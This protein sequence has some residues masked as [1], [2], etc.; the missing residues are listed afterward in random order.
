M[1]T[2]NQKGIYLTV[3]PQ[4]LH[5]KSKLDYIMMIFNDI[6]I[7][8]KNVSVN[9]GIKS[10]SELTIIPGDIH[11][12]FSEKQEIPHYSI[13][14][15]EGRKLPILFQKT[16]VHPII[17]KSQNNRITIKGDILMSA[18]YF[19]SCW[20]EY[21][22]NESDSM[23]RFPFEKSLLFKLKLIQTPIVNYYFDILVKAIENI[24]EVEVS[25]NPK[26]SD[27]LKI[28]IT[29]DIDHCQTGSWQ[30]GYRQFMAGE[31]WNGI[32]KW[33]QRLYKKDLWF[34]FDHL[35]KI[36]NDLGVTSS[37]YFIT[38]QNRKN[39]YPNA[40]YNFKSTQIQTVMNSIQASGHEVGIHGSIGTGI[41]KTALNQEISEFDHPVKGGRF[42]YL[43]MR[44]PQS[45][46]ILESSGLA[47]DT[48]VGFAEHIGFRNGFCFP[49]YPYDF[50]H[51]KPYSFLEFPFQMMDKT[52]IQPYYMG[53]KPED[54][55]QSVKILMD[56]IRKFSGY[57]IFIWHNNT[58]MG[59]KY[60]QWE[61][62]FINTIKYGLDIQANFQPISSFAIR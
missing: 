45:F 31:W 50:K 58:I 47:Y 7:L 4:Y 51:E 39:G 36:E 2:F 30:D 48:S 34:N 14:E 24:S 25:I 53:L 40:D 56:E 57:F 52:L 32:K 38:K 16:D 62:V 10:G 11:S 43:M 13:Y 44:I 9:Y 60:K 46:T 12:F 3:E 37:Y 20:Q 23:G 26:H 41:E 1:E 33:C 17:S 59:F 8:S 19:L 18:F 42:H 29:H 6:F 15:W 5:L 22:S 27:G 21:V 28:G 35:L 49:Y 54:A 61:A 55:I